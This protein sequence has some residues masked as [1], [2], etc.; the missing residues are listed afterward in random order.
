[1]KM[2]QNK[3]MERQ[4][5]YY[6][7]QQICVN[8][9]LKTLIKKNQEKKKELPDTSNNNSNDNNNN[10]DNLDEIEDNINNNSFV[11]NMALLDVINEP[12][13]P[14]PPQNQNDN[15]NNN[16]QVMQNELITEVIIDVMN[17]N[18]NLISGLGNNI[19]GKWAHG[20]NRGG[21][22]YN[23]PDGWIGYGL[24]VLSKYDNGNN[25]WLACNGRP[26]EWCV[27]YHGACH[28]QSSDE[29][30][31]KI[32]LILETNL[33]PGSGQ[34]YSSYDD[35]NHPGQKVG[36]GVYCSPNPSVIDGYAGIMEV[37]GHNY[38]VAFM[39]RVKPDK[40]RYSSSQP[41]YWVVNGNFDE[42]RP[43]RLLIKQTN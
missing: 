36:V 39:L 28:G 18:P 23:P 9:L 10:V 4:F 24:N 21:R 19:E 12:N 22:P 33:K 2:I 11:P 30:K 31:K 27:A 17:L 32:K 3:M 43:Y 14:N 7:Y 41:D 8:Q 37:H 16:N 40:I 42:L 1:M 6:I 5:F 26:G 35:A 38:K 29:V 20:E 13:P 34:A 25:D 15:Q